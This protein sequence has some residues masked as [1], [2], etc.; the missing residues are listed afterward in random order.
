MRP[1]TGRVLATALALLLAA[2]VSVTGCS[3][4]EV[5][6]FG[7]VLPLTGES[8][9]YGTPI[10]NGIELALQ[11]IEAKKD[12]P[13]IKLDIR[14]SQSD[15][16]RAQQLT[17]ELYN[18]GERAVVGG[19]T[20]PEAMAMVEAADRASRVLVSPSASAAALT[21]ISRNFFR[22]WPSDARE[23]AKMGQYAAQNLNLQ[24][25]VIITADSTYAEGIQHVFREAFEQNGGKVLETI[26][27]P[28]NTADVEALVERA[29]SLTPDCIYV[30]DYADGIVKLIKLLKAADYKGKILTVAA[31]ATPQAI[32][33]AGRDA[34]GV[35]VTHPQFS[36]ASDDPEVKAF[37]EAYRKTYGE[38]PGLYA[39]HGYDA[40]MVLY[41]A[42]LEGGDSGSN[43]WKGIRG[44]TTLKGVTGP[45]QFDDKGDV[46]KWPR[47]YFLVDGALVDHSDWVD[48]QKEK[49][50]ERM[51]QLR[52]E[53]RA[54]QRSQNG[55]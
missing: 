10:R 44:I 1:T 17:E 28:R 50:R 7:V 6:T 37:V 18:E 36:E 14:D 2:F 23:G 20:T 51:D 43:F 27:Y 40:M 33:A 22:V 31:F 46:Q 13:P 48:E 8:A 3:K 45:L 34:E 47:V 15:P 54:L 24:T 30:A 5:I 9:I 26:E 16:Q 53:R 4:K 42:V 29:V 38:S 41:N 19:V 32:S 25:A 52:R 11:Q 21:G 12:A 55:G 49:L 39:A 35:F